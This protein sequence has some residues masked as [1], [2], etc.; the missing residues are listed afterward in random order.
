M[1]TKPITRV[2]V[3]RGTGKCEAVVNGLVNQEVQRLQKIEHDKF[4]AER[5]AFR[6]ELVRLGLVES[7]RNRMLAQRLREIEEKLRPRKEPAIKRVYEKLFA[8]G[9]CFCKGLVVREYDNT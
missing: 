4:E 1:S 9:V 2:S 5:Q 7:S 3:I 6:A 8:C